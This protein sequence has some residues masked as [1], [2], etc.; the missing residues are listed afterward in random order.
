MLSAM[1]DAPHWL[2]WEELCADPSLQDLPYRIELN[3][4]NQIVMS[5]LH[6]KHGRYQGKIIKLLDQLL[7][8]GDASVEAAISTSDNMK[9]PDVIWAPHEFFRQHADA[10][11]LPV[12]PDICIEVLSP[13]N[14]TLEIDQK[15]QLYFESGAKEVWICGLK[16]EMKFYLPSGQAESSVLCPD[17]PSQIEL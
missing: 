11:A 3:G 15:C 17:F 14:R 10:F 2:T 12:A 9:V 16:G 1:S 5:P 4:S 13:T 8:T 7:P 6:F